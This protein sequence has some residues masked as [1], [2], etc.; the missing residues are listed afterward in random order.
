[1]CRVSKKDRERAYYLLRQRLHLEKVLETG[2]CSQTEILL[3]EHELFTVR[4]WLKWLCIPRQVLEEYIES[5]E[6]MRR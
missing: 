1:M 3:R 5:I 4:L 6:L 2:K